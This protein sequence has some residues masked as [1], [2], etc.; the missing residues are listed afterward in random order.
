MR[1]LPVL[2]LLAAACGDDGSTE[3]RTATFSLQV[4]H[5]SRLDIAGDASFTADLGN[6]D[7]GTAFALRDQPAGGTLRHSIALFRYISDPLAPGDYPIVVGDESDPPAGFRASL[8]LERDGGD[9]LTCHGDGGVLRVTRADASNVV[10][11]LTLKGVCARTSD[12]TNT[13]PFTATGVLHAEEGLPGPG[14][15]VPVR[16]GA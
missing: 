14:E 8:S 2:L 7:I 16:I 5:A 11:A 15:A 3:P 6:S 10:G 4:Q 13:T 12:P 1:K 9:P